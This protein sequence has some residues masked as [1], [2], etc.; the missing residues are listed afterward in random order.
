MSQDK[1]KVINVAS[2][3]LYDLV[4]RVDTAKPKP[5]DVA[6]LRRKLRD[7]HALC[8]QILDLTE[9]TEAQL[10]DS[11]AGDSALIAEAIRG[12]LAHRRRALGYEEARDLERLLIEQVILTWLHYYRVQYSYRQMAGKELLIVQEDRW[13][14]KLNAAQRRHLRA[15]ETLSRVRKLSGRSAIQINI[16]EQQ[17][18]VAG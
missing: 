16:A 12:D 10:I 9:L 6:L 1:P 7:N 15:I 4:K 13:E 18:N 8:K 5:E 17:V 11:L 14:R 3:E 2:K